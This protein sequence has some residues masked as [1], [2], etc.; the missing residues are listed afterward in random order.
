MIGLVAAALLAA[1]SVSSQA[2]VWTW[3]PM[4]D[5]TATVFAVLWRH[6]FDDDAG[7]ECGAAGALAECRLARARRA[8]PGVTASGVQVTGD[9]TVAFVLVPASAAAD[10]VAFCGALLDDTVAVG[11]DLVAAAIARA[12]LAAD[13]AEWLYPG[14]VLAS[15]ARRA[16]LDGAAAH[17]VA[18][19]ATALQAL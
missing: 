7:H 14:P 19:S 18:G 11:D 15:R 1:P 3:Q 12:A 13:D 8:A 4:P 2:P 17:A 9:A 5:A 6:G 10:G 16:A